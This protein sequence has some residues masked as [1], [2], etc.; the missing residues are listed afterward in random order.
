MQ[1]LLRVITETLVHALFLQ[2]I[3]NLGGCQQ[4]QYYAVLSVLRLKKLFKLSYSDIF[5]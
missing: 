5:V 4:I 1:I 3:F 2:L